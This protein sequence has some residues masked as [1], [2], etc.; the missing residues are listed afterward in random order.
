LVCWYSQTGERTTNSCFK[1]NRAQEHEITN[2]VDKE[3][4][5]TEKL[6]IFLHRCG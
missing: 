4:T 1:T 6:A 5:S 3:F 2:T